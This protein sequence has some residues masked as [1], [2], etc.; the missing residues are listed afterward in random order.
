[1]QVVG[2]PRQITQ[3][4]RHR[5]LET[6][7]RRRPERLLG[8]GGR[9]APLDPLPMAKTR[10]KRAHR[11]PL[12]T[13]PPRAPDTVVPGAGRGR[14]RDPQRL[15]HAG[16]DRKRRPRP[17]TGLRRQRK[18]RR[19]HPQIPCRKRT[20]LPR[21]RTPP[22]SPP[23]HTTKTPLGKAPAQRTQTLPTRKNRPARH[24]LHNLDRRTTD[25]RAVHRI[26]PRDPLDTRPGMEARNRSQR[27]T[28]PR[29]T[30]GR[31]ALPHP[32][33]PGRRRL[34]VFPKPAI[35]VTVIAFNILRDGIRDMMDPR[36]R[37]SVR[38]L[39]SARRIERFRRK[40]ATAKGRAAV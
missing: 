23:R 19:T 11:T 1:M 10:P 2:L 40:D 29:Q 30:P 28:L 5:T 6:G 15:S 37:G 18:H 32:S 16:Q 34:H 35:T 12:A 3:G 38:N 26:R 9:Y 14:A 20:R 33:H 36:P 4:D 39:R 22:K 17:T 7:P 25:H 24:T 31:H 13:P 21:P 27:Q 8:G